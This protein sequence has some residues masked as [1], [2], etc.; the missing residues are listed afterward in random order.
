MP[1]D[2]GIIMN[3]RRVTYATSDDAYTESRAE[4]SEKDIE[5][6]KGSGLPKRPSIGHHFREK[7]VLFD[8][9][10]IFTKRPLGK[11]TAIGELVVKHW[12]Y[13]T[14]VVMSQNSKYIPQERIKEIIK[15]AKTHGLNVLDG[16][17]GMHL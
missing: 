12:S 4:A 6:H 9:E 8:R 5:R 13:D 3:P 2:I 1:I 10:D 15:V 7:N 14:V 16:S 17:T 11:R